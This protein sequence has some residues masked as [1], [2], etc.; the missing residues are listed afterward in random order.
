MA[1]ELL[2]VGWLFLSIIISGFWISRRGKPYST[3]ILTVH[4]L[5]G[6]GTGIYLAGSVYQLYQ[7]GQLSPADTTAILVTILLFIGLVASG[8]LLSTG[9]PVPAGVSLIQKFFPYLTLVST[10]FSLYLLSLDQ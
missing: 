3:L 2:L 8:G 9:K 10:T 1:S 7:S 6:L 4:K 5:I